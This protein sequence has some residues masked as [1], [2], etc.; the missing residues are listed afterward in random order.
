M[1]KGK[2]EKGKKESDSQSISFKQAM[3]VM[4]KARQTLLEV[5]EYVKMLK[6][7]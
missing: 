5:K 3:Y 1:E 2:Q 7:L 6:R 4:L